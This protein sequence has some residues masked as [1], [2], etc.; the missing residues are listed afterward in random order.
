MDPLPLST[1]EPASFGNLTMRVRIPSVIRTVAST[2]PEF[3]PD[4]LAELEKFAHEV[5]T[6]A[7]L[8]A[9]VGTAG[10]EQ[11][12]FDDEWR[13]V[14]QLH[15][16]AGW[17]RMPWYEAEAYMYRCLLD[18]TLYHAPHKRRPSC[19]AR[20]R[21]R[22]CAQRWRSRQH[23]PRR[24]TPMHSPHCSDFACS[25]TRPISVTPR[26]RRHCRALAASPVSTS[27][28][29]WSMMKPRSLSMSSRRLHVPRKKKP[30]LQNC[31][32]L[33]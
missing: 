18:I 22:W 24:L 9:L 13:R 12:E 6:G 8:R 32:N 7:P 5:E 33:P 23:R 3:A 21:G 26:W 25:A 29:F 1:G 30:C 14:F 10:A 20:A 31:W 2:N 11:T 4:V 19:A 27:P 15:V 28:C 17:L 16:Q